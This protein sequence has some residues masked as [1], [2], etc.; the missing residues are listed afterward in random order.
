MKIERGE[1]KRGKEGGCHTTQPFVILSP[2]KNGKRGKRG[3]GGKKRG[4][5]SLITYIIERRGEEGKKT[6]E[7]RNER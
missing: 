1:E 7:K 3:M 2:A 5:V 6:K 4:E